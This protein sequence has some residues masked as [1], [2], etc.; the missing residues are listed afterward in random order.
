VADASQTAATEIHLGDPIAAGLVLTRYW[1]MAVP[2]TVARQRR[3][4]FNLHGGYPTLPGI[5]NAGAVCK[6]VTLADVG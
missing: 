4:T 6:V 5:A 2:A 3:H 1:G